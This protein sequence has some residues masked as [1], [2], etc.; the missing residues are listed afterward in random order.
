MKTLKIPC[1]VVCIDD[2]PNPHPAIIRHARPWVKKGHVYRVK[3][4]DG[5][6]GLYLVGLD[7][8]L[9]SSSSG[10]GVENIGLLSSRFSQFGNDLIEVKIDKTDSYI[11]LPPP[12]PVTSTHSRLNKVTTKSSS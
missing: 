11:E 5:K 4:I 1:E 3:A 2:T 9:V 10:I 8:G 7:C 12:L 6:G